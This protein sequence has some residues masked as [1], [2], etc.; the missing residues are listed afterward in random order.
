[1]N[2]INEKGIECIIHGDKRMLKLYLLISYVAAVVRVP[3]Q[4]LVQFNGYYSYSWC[5]RRTAYRCVR[6]PILYYYPKDRK[7]ADIIECE[8]QAVRC[9]TIIKGVKYV[10]PLINLPFL[11]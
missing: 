6:F 5:L 3:M 8:K 4:G 9:G 7:V 11:I 10:T 2:V 1:M